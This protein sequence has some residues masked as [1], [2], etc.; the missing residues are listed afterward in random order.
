MVKNLHNDVIDNMANVETGKL[1]CKSIFQGFGG[2]PSLGRYVPVPRS[3]GHSQS[4][5]GF[6]LPPGPALAQ[7]PHR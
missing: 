1:N 5:R 2:I 7:E 3:H 4:G 6:S